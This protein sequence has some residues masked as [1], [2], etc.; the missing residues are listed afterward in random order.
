MR[1]IAAMSHVLRLLIAALAFVGCGPGGPASMA[2]NDVGTV[3][4]NVQEERSA[5]WTVTAAPVLEPLHA[6]ALCS[7]MDVTKLT[8]GTN[9]QAAI[10]GDL[11]GDGFVDLVIPG[12]SVAL[13]TVYF[14]GPSGFAAPQTLTLPNGPVLGFITDGDGDGR[15][16]L[17]FVVGRDVGFGSVFARAL[18]ARAFS[19]GP[20]AAWGDSFGYVAAVGDVSGDGRPDVVGM[21]QNPRVIQPQTPRDSMTLMLGGPNGA[22][23]K[24]PTLATGRDPSFAVGLDFDGDG[25]RDIAVSEAIGGVSLFRNDGSSGLAYAGTY[26]AGPSPAV[27]AA[28]DFDSDGDEDLAV[29]NLGYSWSGWLVGVLVNDGSGGFSLQRTTKD[30]I[31]VGAVLIVDSDGDGVLELVVTSYREGELVFLSLSKTDTS[32]LTIDRRVHTGNS[33]LWLSAV[34][35]SPQDRGRALVVTDTANEGASVSVVRHSRGV[36]RPE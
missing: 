10:S 15:N 17:I 8:T 31:D 25:D 32:R 21:N 34:R 7:F 12:G 16:D 5:P 28:G 23:T 22:F 14:G 36:C 33:A 1:I 18:G 24:G 9:P 30:I 11:D 2:M 26:G 27:L 4:P 3:T 35:I 20:V 13:A 6:P 19:V 29:T